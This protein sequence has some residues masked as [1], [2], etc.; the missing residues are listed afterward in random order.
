MKS[1]LFTRHSFAEYSYYKKDYDREITSEGFSKILE[2]AQI[3][4]DKNIY[5]DLIISSSAKRA[6]QTAKEF[7]KHLNIKS[8]IIEYDWLYEDY[9]TQD[10]TELL[11]KISND[12]SSIMLIAHNPMIS[13]MASKFNHSKNYLFNPTSIVKFDFNINLWEQINVRTG[14]EDFY[15]E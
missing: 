11:Q 9:T 6:L 7:K 8:D 15:L 4:K 5:I 1:I 13:V 2:Q 12:K 14:K 3:L 10:I